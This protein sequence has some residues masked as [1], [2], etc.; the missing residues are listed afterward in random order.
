M[1]HWFPLLALM[2]EA[3]TPSVTVT[4][5]AVNQVVVRRGSARLAVY[6]GPAAE[7]VLY[8]H[9]RRDAFRPV[10]GGE[11]VVPAAEEAYFRDPMRFWTSF[12]KERFH[13]YEARSS[14]WPVEPVT[15]KLVP[16][17]DGAVIP[18]R[19]IEFRVIATPGVTA[20]AI[21]YLATIDKQK[22]AFTGD[23]I[24]GDGQLLELHSLQAGVPETKTRGYHGY[25][26]R[27]AD[28]IAS[29]RKIAA[30][31][32][33]LLIPAR[34]PVIRDPQAAIAKLTGRLHAFFRGHFEIDA[35]RWYWGDENLRT[36][37]GR[38]LGSLADM[39]W[40]EMSEQRKLPAWVTPIQNSR[41]IH[42]AD[43]VEWLI[44][45][46]NAR[47]LAEVQKRSKKVEGIFITHY[48]DDHTDHAQAAADAL[49]AKVYA[50]PELADVLRHPR[51]YRLPAGTANP[52][53]SLVTM[54]EGTKV[55]WHEFEFTYLY[56]PGQT[57]YHG[58]LLVKKDGGETLF[59]VGDSFTPSGIDEYCL[60]NRNLLD[61]DQGYLYCLRK[62]REMPEQPWLINQHV[63]PMFR[64]TAAEIARM[65]TTQ[66]QRRAV[67][68]ELT[69]FPHPN[70]AV[71]EQWA[72]FEPYEVTARPGA[73][74][75]LNLRLT[76]HS[77]RTE[78]FLVDKTR[79]SLPA[80]QTR[81]V[82]VTVRVP[83]SAQDFWI[84]TTTIELTGPN[85][86]ASAE[87]MVRLKH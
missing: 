32:P 77:A 53:T 7:T 10:V 26:A 76:N 52:I 80:R 82:P 54:P 72:W 31:K 3:V 17:Q 38:I 85:L 11:I 6:A 33:D 5:G 18:W 30:V 83:A 22:I 14:K 57:L 9:A 4:P 42:S 61:D 2:A 70:F 60:Q 34:G 86:T 67:L 74:L 24:Y 23:L 36:R 66:R 44:D 56:Y 37:A 58:G 27:A 59:F 8:T 75:Q 64:F 47:I 45:C 29:L 51:A 40:M 84:A 25:G 87:A 50:S 65:E 43:G 41:L 13:D 39:K 21:S 81:V 28:L 48:H 1:M 62:L 69:P 20:G 12:A 78:T 68:A 55:R 79:L 35:L 49:R 63:E 16:V 19:G 15:G 46:G 71:D 73:T